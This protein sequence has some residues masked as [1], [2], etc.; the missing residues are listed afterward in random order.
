VHFDR[1]ASAWL[2][3]RF[4][5]PAAEF[6]FL[7]EDEPC[8]PDVTP[9]GLTAGRL[10]AHDASATTFRRILDA[11]AI[12]DAALERLEQLIA[13]GVAHVLQDQDP[14]AIG[15]RDPLTGGVLAVAEGLMLLSA[16]DASCLQ[17]S[18]GLYDA[19]H[20]RLQA[21]P[22]VGAA[23]PGAPVLVRTLAFARGVAALRQAGAR[24]APDAFRAALEGAG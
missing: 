18:F 13:A 9:F 19:L 6:L 20:A 3:A 22:L 2:V 17:R 14:A 4:I 1:A 7:A 8:P 21:E 11:F 5:D 10:A 12:E 16:D 24:F 15:R 23:R